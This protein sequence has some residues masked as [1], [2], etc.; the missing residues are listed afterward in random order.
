MKEQAI[1]IKTKYFVRDAARMSSFVS[2]L[3][4]F[5]N[6]NLLIYLFVHLLE[7]CFISLYP[8]SW[9]NIFTKEALDQDA[10]K[11]L[12]E[13]EII[14]NHERLTYLASH[15]MFLLFSVQCRPSVTGY[16][17]NL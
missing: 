7:K 16:G 4:E 2:L 13:E 15:I 9:E 17:W 10:W 3:L 11:S 12:F 14:P 5:C 8:Q 1:H 6:S